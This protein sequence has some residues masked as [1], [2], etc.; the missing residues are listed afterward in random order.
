MQ[1]VRT[2]LL[3]IYNVPG[4]GCTAK[5]EFSLYIPSAMTAIALLE[6]YQDVIK[7]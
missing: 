1:H 2:P 5:N 6:A 3:N 7:K 4:A